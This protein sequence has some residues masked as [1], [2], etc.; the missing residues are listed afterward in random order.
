MNG[1]R[2]VEIMLCRSAVE[3]VERIQSTLKDLGL[4]KEEAIDSGLINTREEILL[5]LSEKQKTN[6]INNRLVFG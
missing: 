5:N 1:F 4:S 6:P 2:F 3:E